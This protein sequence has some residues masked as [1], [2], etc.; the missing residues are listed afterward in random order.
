M[1]KRL[2]KQEKLLIGNPEDLVKQGAHALFFPHGIGHLLS[3][4]VHDM[5]NFG[6][7]AA[8]SEGRQRSTQFGTAYLRMDLDLEPNMVV[9]IEPGL[10]IVPAILHNSDLRRQFAKTINWSL[11]EKWIGFGGIR[12]EDDI[13]CTDGVS[14]NLSESIPKSIEEIESLVSTT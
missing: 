13:R 6:D 11:A 4:D 1:T 2:K 5:E 12:I 7:I 8:Y 9:T 10:Y 14:E 3:L